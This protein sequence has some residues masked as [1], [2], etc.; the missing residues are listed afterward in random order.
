MSEE[1]ALFRRCP[2][3]AALRWVRDARR[4]GAACAT[5]LAAY[6]RRQAGVE[7]RRG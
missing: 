5:A 6:W 1:P 2:M 3:C 4:T 7:Q